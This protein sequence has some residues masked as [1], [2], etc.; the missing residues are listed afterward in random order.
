MESEQAGER[1]CPRCGAS[2][3]PDARFCEQCGAQ[4][5][6][7]AG[8]N[9]EAC[10]AALGPAAR[11]CTH[12]GAWAGLKPVRR[13]SIAGP[14]WDERLRAGGERL[15]TRVA[16]IDWVRVGRV[17]LPA[18]ALLL[19]ALLGY[20]LGRRGDRPASSGQRVVTAARGWRGEN[21]RPV[22]F[23]DFQVSATSWEQAHPPALAADGDPYTF[24]HAWKSEKFPEGEWLTLTFPEKRRITRIGLLPGR[25]GAGARAEG[26]IK[27]LLVKAP[28]AA[29]QKLL[30]DDR[31]EIQYR[32]LKTPV[33]ARQ[34]ILRIGTVRPGRETRHIVI[35]EVQ[36]WG[37]PVPEQ[38]TL[39]QKVEPGNPPP[40]G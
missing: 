1:T 7:L 32:D 5:G 39:R 26:R 35:P 6:S 25:A 8:R 10:G 18:A 28:G 36:A 29:P 30:F 15:R 13:A 19:A 21:P 38:V 4:L 40:G 23:R 22:R 24:W 20:A 34:L 14:A 9:C 2:A 31:P 33:E 16:A 11:Y 3:S 12:C 37:Y 27:S 17:G